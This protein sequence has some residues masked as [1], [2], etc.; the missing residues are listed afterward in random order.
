MDAGVE[1]EETNQNPRVLVID[2]DPHIVRQVRRIL[3][4]HGYELLMA[5][6]GQAGLNLFRQ[7]NPD[8]VLL[9]LELADVA[10]QDVLGQMKAARRYVPVMILASA[11]EMAAVTSLRR[12][13]DDY[14]SKPLAP[15]ELL[16]R[17]R[18]NLERGRQ[19]RIQNELTEQLQRQVTMLLSVREVAR[20]ASGTAD[21][22]QLL[23]RVLDQT[24]QN[25]KLDAGIIFVSE[26]GDLIPL[27]Y[28]GLPPAIASALTRRR[29]TWN[30]PPLRPFQEVNQTTRTRPEEQRGGP[31]SLSVG[32]NFTAVVPLWAQ[33]RRRGL[34]EVAR[35]EERPGVAQDMEVLTTV[36]HQVAV[37]L[38]NTRLQET[39]ALR[40]RELALLNE[41]CLAL[42]SDLDLEQILTTIMLRTSDVI[43]VETGSLLLLDEA[44]NELV[45][46]IS[47]GGNADGVLARRIPPGQGISGWVFQQGQALLVPNVQTDPRYYP[48]VDQFT[49]FQ[50]RSIL[51]V[52]LRVRGQRFGVIELVNKVVG[53]FTPD[54]LRL[55]ES[56]AALTA[57]AIEQSRLH[58]WTTS[59]ILVDPVTRLP[60]HRLFVEALERESARSRRY[61]RTCSLLLLGVDRRLHLSDTAWRELAAAIK[62]ALRKSDLLCRHRDGRF[63]VI[64]P[65]TGASGARQLVSRL[66]QGI[67]RAGLLEPD[68]SPLV[69]HIRCGHATFPEEVD[70]PKALIERA[71]SSLAQ[72]WQEGRV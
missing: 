50:T 61:G 12:G 1:A 16:E 4:Q 37:A 19:A 23:H 46:R 58:E 33:G 14:L 72:S 22:Y 11:S 36:G 64:L 28:R 47:L 30:D 32:Y 7:E 17:V 60:N 49:G 63:V 18:H 44:S 10:G 66:M 54:D 21:L 52:P 43:G 39:A 51:C 57:T 8:L 9:D 41:A 65:E 25:L 71:E 27:A 35:R 5:T 6:G 62:R 69:D 67:R 68:G 24:L 3:E 55:L 40:V 20:E 42:T 56:V 2:R 38:A 48:E 31:L 34:L 53:E 15:D 45:F 59:F 70:D 13:A 29:L 26:D